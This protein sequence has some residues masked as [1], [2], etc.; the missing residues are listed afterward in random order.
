MPTK[1]FHKT[2]NEHAGVHVGA[3][4]KTIKSHHEVQGDIEENYTYI[5]SDREGE[6][7]DD[8]DD[9]GNYRED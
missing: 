3:K 5:D 7:L 9:T 1:E 6:G 8:N 4:F 2:S